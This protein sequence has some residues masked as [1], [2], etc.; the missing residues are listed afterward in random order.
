MNYLGEERTREIRRQMSKEDVA[1]YEQLGKGIFSRIQIKD[2]P[3]GS[4]GVKVTMSR[5]DPRDK[6]ALVL[7]SAVKSGLDACDLDDEDR[8]FALEYWG[9]RW[10]ETMISSGLKA[11]PGTGKRITEEDLLENMPEAQRPR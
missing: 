3:D 5:D 4:V 2:N 6:H 1:H 8:L 10:E 11:I 7:L 9:S